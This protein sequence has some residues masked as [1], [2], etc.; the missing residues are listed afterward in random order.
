VDGYY[1]VLPDGCHAD[2]GGG[3]SAAYGDCL[4]QKRA[5]ERCAGGH[6]GPA[7]H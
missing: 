4:S 6:V 2:D 1:V 3:E 5:L 7:A